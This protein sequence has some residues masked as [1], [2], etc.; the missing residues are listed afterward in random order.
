VKTSSNNCCYAQIKTRCLGK[1]ALD[2]CA[3]S[4][5]CLFVCLIQS[6]YSRWPYEPSIS[7]PFLYSFSI[8]PDLSFQAVSPLSMYLSFDSKIPYLCF[9]P[10]S[11]VMSVSTFI[12]ATLL[13]LTIPPSRRVGL[14]VG[15]YL[16]ASLSL[17]APSSLLLV[18]SPVLSYSSSVV[19]CLRW[20]LHFL[21]K[22]G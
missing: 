6:G 1:T 12:D 20:N 14:K 18:L 9:Y 16:L 5:V 21:S 2:P 4:L 22:I 13:S 8:L 7:L 10:N 11:S 19:I 3:L 15:L 17:L